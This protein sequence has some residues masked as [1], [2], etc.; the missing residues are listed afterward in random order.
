MST[1][2]P[3]TAVL[4]L[5][6]GSGSR[7]GAGRNKVYLPLA[8]R[9]VL[10]WSLSTFAGVA[11]VA[12]LVLVV[13]PED[14]GNVS[15]MLTTEVPGLDVEVVAG[16]CTRQASELAGLT[17]LTGRIASGEI[18]TVLIHDG[19]RPLVSPELVRA[20]IAGAREYGG[21]VPGTRV[22]E[23]ATADDDGLTGLVA[24]ELVAVQTP[25]GFAAAAVLEAYQRAALDDYVGTDTASCVRHYTDVAVRWI[26]GEESNLKITY[27]HDLT[28]AEALLRGRLTNP[29][30]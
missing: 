6:G 18:S 2:T 15:S 1:S 14:T 20:V 9:S 23:L 13:R 7:F 17:H 4:L 30:D 11:E 5:A 26:P 12:A 21:A 10:S 16:G 27:A 19:A 24:E 28:V 8:G 22:T 29:Q 3:D 25:Q